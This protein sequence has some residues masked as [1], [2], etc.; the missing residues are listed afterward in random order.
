[1]P[2]NLPT[3]THH[4]ASKHA[5][6]RRCRCDSRQSLF[7]SCPPFS[8][9]F[10][11]IVCLHLQLLPL[12]LFVVMSAER[13]TTPQYC[14]L[15]VLSAQL[16]T[17]VS[18]SHMQLQMPRRLLNTASV[19]PISLLPTLPPPPRLLPLRLL[20]PR[21]MP[22]RLLLLRQLSRLIRQR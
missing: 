11:C 19:P 8:S 21:W 4:D 17:A 14:R 9:S 18:H 6:V 1:M 13:C 20:L 5:S 22:L 16:L 15:V 2:L 12:A 7:F 10:R 3:C